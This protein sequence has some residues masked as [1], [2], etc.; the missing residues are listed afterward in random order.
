MLSRREAWAR[1]LTTAHK[2]DVMACPRHGSRTAVIA[3][4]A[5]PARIRK[6]IA[7]RDR[8]EKG[9]RCCTIA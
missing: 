7:C 1:L 5:N 3:L 4:I 6:I 9:P 2:L 8:H